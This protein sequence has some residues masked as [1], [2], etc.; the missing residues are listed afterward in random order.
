MKLLV[1]KILLFN[2]LLLLC[3]SC[4]KQVSDWEIPANKNEFHIFIL[5]GQSNMAGFDFLLDS[6][7][8]SVSHVLKIP[9]ILDSNM[10][11]VPASHPLHNRTATDRFGLGLSFAEKYKET[12]KGVTVG[13][14]PLANGGKEIDRLNKGSEVYDDFLRKVE[15]A[16]GQGVL[17]GV[18][19]HQGESD[20]VEE[21]LANT[22][23]TKLHKLISDIRKDV[24]DPK[25]PFIV[26]NL[27]EFYGTGT[28][29]NKPERVRRI[30][31]VS[32]VLR[33]LPNKVNFT[34]F[35]ESTGCTSMDHY[36]VHFDR[37]SYIILGQRYFD[38]YLKIAE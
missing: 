30:K 35:V 19:W 27:A 15:F 8:I 31:H 6:D 22:Y 29:H 9:T 3:T 36:N 24:A 33:N 25:L 7:T 14:I 20:T 18:L 23:E 26:G 13:L 10:E 17:K 16:K 21:I 32:Q 37:E 11:W 12:Y 4:N 2:T 34:G 28:E 1:L 38:A 5:M